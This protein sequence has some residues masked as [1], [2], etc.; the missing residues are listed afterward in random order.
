MNIP[1]F[2]WK[3]SLMSDGVQ[4]LFEIIGDI[5]VLHKSDVVK[6]FERDVFVDVAFESI[7]K[8]LMYLNS[9]TLSIVDEVYRRG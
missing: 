1:L 4:R 9:K 6:S 7:D 5:D 3:I 2:Q 8:Y